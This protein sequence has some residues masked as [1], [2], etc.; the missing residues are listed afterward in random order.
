MASNTRVPKAAILLFR[1]LIV[2]PPLMREFGR[3]WR[4][5]THELRR[6]DAH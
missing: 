3:E 2:Y 4:K 6:A 1:H 5:P